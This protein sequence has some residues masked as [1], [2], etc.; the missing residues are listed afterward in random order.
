MGILNVSGDVSILAANIIRVKD[1]ELLAEGGLIKSSVGYHFHLRMSKKGK[2][3]FYKASKKDPRKWMD[4]VDPEDRLRWE[5][6]ITQL[7]E[8]IKNA[9]SLDS[10][11]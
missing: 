1:E 6:L 5:S 11:T 7:M 9:P 2:E 8:A 10:Y 3:I 4:T